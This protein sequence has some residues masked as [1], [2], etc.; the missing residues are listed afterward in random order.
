MDLAQLRALQG[1]LKEKYRHDPATA[2]VTSHATAQLVPGAIAVDVETGG[3]PIHAGLHPSTGGD[4]TL[5]CSGDLVLQALVACAGVTLSAVAT[6]MG[7]GI[8]SGAIHAEADWDARGT[9]GVSKEAPVG[10]TAVR[11][12]AE[13][14]S[15]ATPEQRA[16]LL[17]LT[18]RYCVV[19]QT[20]RHGVTVSIA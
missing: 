4:G 2:R 18:E 6:A 9:L 12:R 5:A 19:A 8:R 7:I 1:P 17:E 13:L 15:D 16:R 10:F 3:A 11:L 14:D 20:L